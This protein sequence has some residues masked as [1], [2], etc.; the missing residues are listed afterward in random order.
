M[1]KDISTF[2]TARVALTVRDLQAVGR[3]YEETVGLHRLGGDA[4]QASYGT[5]GGT[6]LLELRRDTAARRASP[7]DAGLFHTAFLLA[8]RRELGA[9]LAH[10]AARGTRLDGVADHAVS[11]ALYL[12]DPEGNGVEIYMDR[13]RR[14]WPVEDGMI[15]MV[16]DPLDIDGLLKAGKGVAWKGFPA[17]ATLGHVHLQVG[18]VPEAETFWTRTMGLALTCRYPGASFFGADGYH[19]HIA[20]NIWNSRGAG[21]RPSPATG[22]AEVA[23]EVT[24][25][26]VAAIR[27]EAR[28]AG[29]AANF[30]VEDPWGTLFA[31]SVI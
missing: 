29:D 31:L 21:P 1:S 25:E 4:E 3:W 24:R 27:A 7:R 22:L 12:S 2:R 16:S 6:P 5:A 10:A 9:W 11:E 17:S 15:R 20:T 28:I 23:L 8:E 30:T 18:R 26:R 13:P 14:E 19:H